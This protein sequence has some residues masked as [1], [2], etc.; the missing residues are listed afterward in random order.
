M[1]IA[2]SLSAALAAATLLIAVVPEAA[3]AQFIAGNSQGRGNYNQPT[4]GGAGPDMLAAI[5]PTHRRVPRRRLLAHSQA[6][7]DHYVSYDAKTD[8]WTDWNGDKQRCTIWPF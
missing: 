3:F 2:K 4:Y 6:C 5:A 7:S 8:M 1:S